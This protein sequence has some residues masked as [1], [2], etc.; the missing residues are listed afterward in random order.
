MGDSVALGSAV[1]EAADRIRDELG[2]AGV[3]VLVIKDDLSYGAVANPDVPFDVLLGCLIS[4]LGELRAQFLD[5][6]AK[7]KK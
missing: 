3:F 7:E 2:A 5:D 1:H 6:V 4:V